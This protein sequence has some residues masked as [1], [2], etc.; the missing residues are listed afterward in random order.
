MRQAAVDADFVELPPERAQR[1]PGGRG[2]LRSAF[3]P[4][5]LL[6]SALPV[7]MA[8]RPTGPGTKALPVAAPSSPVTVQDVSARLA[9]ANGLRVLIVYG[10]LVNEG[11]TPAALP[12]LDIDLDD[13]RLIRPLD[14][15]AWMLPG[16]VLPFALKFAHAGGAM[17]RVQVSAARGQG[18]AA[19][20]RP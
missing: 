17:P 2:T 13:R 9:D 16:E 20:L 14:G 4:L 6:L 11:R 8:P 1:R 5:I 18:A 10:R 19:A 12:A 15:A 3:L 7:L